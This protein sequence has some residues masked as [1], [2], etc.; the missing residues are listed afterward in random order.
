MASCEKCFFS[1][2]MGRGKN[3][4]GKEVIARVCRRNPPAVFPLPA[5]A[6]RAVVAQPGKGMQIEP[7]AFFPPC[8]VAPLD[9]CGEYVSQEEGSEEFGEAAPLVV[10]ESSKQN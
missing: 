1:A 3:S 2:V 7:V 9:W 10:P 5:S 8:P 4:E 6:V